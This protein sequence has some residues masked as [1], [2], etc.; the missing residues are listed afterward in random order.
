[1]F[2]FIF[3]A[4]GCVN[5]GEKEIICYFSAYKPLDQGNS[6]GFFLFLCFYGVSFFVSKID[7]SGCKDTKFWNFVFA[8]LLKKPILSHFK[9]ALQHFFCFYCY[10]LFLFFEINWWLHLHTNKILKI[11]FRQF[12]QNSHKYN[13]SK[14]QPFSR[15]QSFI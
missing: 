12:A 9:T 1:M 15:S 14:N 2:F 4:F 13:I 11:C 8:I 10:F 7:D 6:W 3:S 5:E